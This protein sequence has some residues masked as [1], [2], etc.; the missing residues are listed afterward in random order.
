MG[1]LG[2]IYLNWKYLEK[3]PAEIEQYCPPLSAGHVL[4]QMVSNFVMPKNHGGNLLKAQVWEQH[5]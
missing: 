4:V 5:F 2:E 1:A 3:H